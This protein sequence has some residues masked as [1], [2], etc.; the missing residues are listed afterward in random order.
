MTRENADL[1]R[2]AVE[3]YYRADKARLLELVH[4]DLEWTYL[5]PEDPDPRPEVCHGRDQLAWALDHQTGRALASEVEEVV[6]APN[7]RVVVVARTPGADQ[8]RAWHNGDRNILVLTVRAG[9]IVA[10]RAF[11]D[12]AEA[13]QF[14]GLG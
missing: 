10:M 14:A 7:D 8:G 2:E 9:Q 12:Q 5:N 13:S 1:V 11:R 6:P 4:P 3:A